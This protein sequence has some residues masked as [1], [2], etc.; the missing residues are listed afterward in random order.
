MFQSCLPIQMINHQMLDHIRIWIFSLAVSVRYATLQPLYIFCQNNLHWTL[1][2]YF[3]HTFRFDL[4][5]DKNFA[6]EAETFPATSDS[7][8]ILLGH[9]AFTDGFILHITPLPCGL[10]H[11]AERHLSITGV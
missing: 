11:F 7:S 9:S 5:F 8:A 4:V 2:Q 6:P 10:F 3:R 1:D